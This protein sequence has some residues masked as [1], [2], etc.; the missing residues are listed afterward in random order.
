MLTYCFAW[1]THNSRLLAGFH[2]IEDVRIARHTPNFVA[3]SGP[4][5]GTNIQT[6]E[7]ILQARRPLWGLRVPH[8]RPD[9]PYKRVCSSR[10]ARRGPAPR[11]LAKPQ[12]TTF[13]TS[14]SRGSSGPLTVPL[15]LEIAPALCMSAPSPQPEPWPEDPL[16]ALVRLTR[17]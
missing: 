5:S 16:P 9:A 10:Q 6:R 1:P 17:R 14:T 15:P 8:G 13:L 11:K 7:I 12:K 4:C 2:S 3:W